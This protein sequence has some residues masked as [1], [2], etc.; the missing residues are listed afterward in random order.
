MAIQQRP[1]DWI[2]PVC[3]FIYTNF[4][5]L[6]IHSI[7]KEGICVFYV[8]DYVLELVEKLLD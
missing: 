4:C 7:L 1:G 6:V 2:C 3:S 5:R 8:E